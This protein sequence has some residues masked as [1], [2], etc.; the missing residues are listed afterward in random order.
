M[1][2]DGGKNDVS[3]SHHRSSSF[4]SLDGFFFSS[5]RGV[6]LIHRLWVVKKILGVG[7]ES[8]MGLIER[9]TKQRSLDFS[10]AWIAVLIGSQYRSIQGW[11]GVTK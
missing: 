8:G 11:I 7:L 1:A 6:D 4:A 9:K 2:A 10:W 5:H 3:P